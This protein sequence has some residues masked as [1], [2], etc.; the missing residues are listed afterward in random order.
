MPRWNTTTIIAGVDFSLCRAVILDGA[1]FA[2]GYRGSVA[3]AADGTPHIQRVAKGVKGNRFGSQMVKARAELILEA[4]TAIRE[5]EAAQEAFRVQEVDGLYD[6]DVWVY[7]DYDVQWFTH[8][9]ES[10]GII[11]NVVF[12]FVALAQYE[13]VP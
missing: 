6:I 13:D 12:R 7:P 4:L 5:A 11:E 2:S 8:G 9:D 10:E 1:Q 3:Q